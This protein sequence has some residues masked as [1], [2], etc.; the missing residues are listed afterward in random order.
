M[1]LLFVGLALRVT[2]RGGLSDDVFT[3]MDCFL[4]H[5]LALLDVSDRLLGRHERLREQLVSHVGTVVDECVDALV[6]EVHG[7]GESVAVHG[8]LGVCMQCRGCDCMMAVRASF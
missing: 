8:G 4:C 3:S 6:V 5:H 1:L 7:K 2:A